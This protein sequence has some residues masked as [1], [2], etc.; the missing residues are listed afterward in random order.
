M[1]RKTTT[2][3]P[4]PITDYV[5]VHELR[6]NGHRTEIMVSLRDK[7]LFAWMPAGEPNTLRVVVPTCWDRPPLHS[8]HVSDVDSRRVLPV[9]EWDDVAHREARISAAK[10]GL[11]V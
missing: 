11:K 1:P 6:L 8:C 4:E 3:E 2:T 10:L 9:A 5:Q 7:H